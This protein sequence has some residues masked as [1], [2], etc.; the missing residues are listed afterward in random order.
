MFKTI[1]KV[2]FILIFSTN[3]KLIIWLFDRVNFFKVLTFQLFIVI[4]FSFSDYYCLIIYSTNRCLIKIIDVSLI[5]VENFKFLATIIGNWYDYIIKIDF[6]EVKFMAK[7]TIFNRFFGNYYFSHLEKLSK[8]I[9]KRTLKVP[10][11]RKIYDLYS[12]LIKFG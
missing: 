1:W 7:F 9:E 11:I 3:S 8:K 10:S 12:C 5:F 2:T 4:N 6:V